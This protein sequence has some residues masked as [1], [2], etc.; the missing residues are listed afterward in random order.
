[1][2]STS[3]VVIVKKPEGM[4]PLNSFLFKARF[5]SLGSP[6]AVKTLGIGPDNELTARDQ[7]MVKVSSLLTQRRQ[8]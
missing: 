2:E 8:A 3:N 4:V 5:S 1:M 6:P 7:R